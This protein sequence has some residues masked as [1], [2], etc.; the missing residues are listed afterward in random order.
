MIL[1]PLIFFILIFKCSSTCLLG[2]A[3][4]YDLITQKNYWLLKDTSS[5]NTS[6]SVKEKLLNICPTYLTTNQNCC[7]KSDKY[8]FLQNISEILKSK[9]NFHK[10]L[11][12]YQNLMQFQCEILC[13]S[14]QNIYL[15]RNATD[16]LFNDTITLPVLKE[17][18]I[19]FN[20]TSSLQLFSSCR[21]VLSDD[22]SINLVDEICGENCSNA[23]EF[24][25]K[26]QTKLYEDYL[27][28]TEIKFEKENGLNI[29]QPIACTEDCPCEDCDLCRSDK[30]I[31]PNIPT[32]K[33]IQEL[34]PLCLMVKLS[35]INLNEYTTITYQNGTITFNGLWKKKLLEEYF[36]IIEKI[37]SL[38]SYSTYCDV[39]GDEECFTYS[40]FNYFQ[41]NKNNFDKIVDKFNYQYHLTFCI[42]NWSE[43]SISE[44]K[45][46]DPYLNLTCSY[47]TLE[48]INNN[49]ILQHHFSESSIQKIFNYSTAFHLLLKFDEDNRFSSDFRCFIGNLSNLIRDYNPKYL[50]IDKVQFSNKSQITTTTTKL[51]STTT[52]S[53]STKSTTTT[54]STTTSQNLTTTEKKSTTTTKKKVTTWTPTTSR[55]TD[56]NPIIKEKTFLYVIVPIGILLAIMIPITF[57]QCVEIRRISKYI[58]VRSDAHRDIIGNDGESTQTLNVTPHIFE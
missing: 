45:S 5:V 29:S 40:I 57:L 54:T 52:K 26:L 46:I 14:K 16:L 38:D 7:N 33:Q 34:C 51:T 12:C 25:T 53:T 18:S 6:R 11:S 13:T 23:E 42:D 37:I 39:G 31:L 20:E 32:E 22:R 48:N 19:T 50:L 43:D 1:Q 27:E 44:D 17:I 49:F 4:V 10:C 47:E 24:L 30:P 9:W 28:K 36:E 15:D 3:P 58:K 55:T 35:A 56:D 41:N 21:S 8:D 2:S